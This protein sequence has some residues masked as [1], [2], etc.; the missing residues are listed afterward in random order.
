MRNKEFDPIMADLSQPNGDVLPLRGFKW[1]N[2]ISVIEIGGIF[3]LSGRGII[4]LIESD[5]VKKDVCFTQMGGYGPFTL[6]Q[7]R[8]AANGHIGPLKEGEFGYVESVQLE[9]NFRDPT[10]EIT[11]GQWILS[12]QTGKFV[13]IT[14]LDTVANPDGTHSYYCRGHAPKGAKILLDK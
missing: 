5:L 9:S 1:S 12:S 7:T 11:P 6:D 4:T 3:Y 8:F 13:F 2:L 10:K 14:G